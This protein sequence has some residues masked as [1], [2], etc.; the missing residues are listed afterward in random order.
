MSK[1]PVTN[2]DSAGS[3][4]HLSTLLREAAEELRLAA[5][6]VQF[7][8]ESQFSP[9]S[10]EKI[11]FVR[12][13]PM[14]VIDATYL[15]DVRDDIETLRTRMSSSLRRNLRAGHRRGVV[16][17][18]GKEEDL[19]RFFE[20][21]SATCQRQN[22][23]PNPPTLEAVRRLWRIFSPTKSIRVTFAECTG[24][25][26]AAKL[27]L[28]F[29]TTVSIWKKGWDGSHGDW[30]PNEL[31]EEETFAWAHG[32]GYEACDFCSFSRA[33]TTC[34]GEGKPAPN[35]L[36][37]S[38]DEYHLRFGGRPR[39]LPPPLVLI[40]NPVL[41]WGYRNFYVPLERRRNRAEVTRQTIQSES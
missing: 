34:L 22:A 37:S 13:N 26:V 30:H 29:G 32:H 18:E 36:L 33:A 23:T 6:I 25:I 21:M 4:H 20:L 14:E 31:L 40:R 8:D 1:G 15:L 38:R 27:N 24:V 2:S 17:R 28:H 11:G 35:T 16:T 7:P 41:R 12:S 10:Y 39:L 5:V 3:S 9:A 19:P